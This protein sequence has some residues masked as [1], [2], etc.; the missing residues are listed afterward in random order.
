MAVDLLSILQNVDI[1]LQ[2]VKKELYAAR[3]EADEDPNSFV[4]STMFCRGNGNLVMVCV[5]EKQI[6]IPAELENKIT[7]LSHDRTHESLV[8]EKNEVDVYFPSKADEGDTDI[9]LGFNTL[10]LYQE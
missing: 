7:E 3:K 10:I 9:Q 1:L 2:P 4:W 6:A 5:E 8:D